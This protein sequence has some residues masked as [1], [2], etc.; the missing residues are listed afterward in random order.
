[1]KITI[2][3]SI[4]FIDEMIRL[5][6]ELEKKGHKILLPTS[7]ETGQTKDWWNNLRIE[8]PS[9][10]IEIKADRMTGHFK[11]VNDS[12]AILV[13][14]YD[15]GGIQ[16]YIGGNTLMEMGLALYLGKKI[17]LWN[18]I[19]GDVSYEEE[20]FGMSPIVLNQDISFIL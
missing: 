10:F 20:I 6:V 12:E 8:N 14:N 16:N 3:G 5:K 1:M 19:P 18:P 13:L 17:F 11:K 9:E 2:C 4:K 7:A 15:K